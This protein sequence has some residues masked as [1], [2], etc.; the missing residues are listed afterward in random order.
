MKQPY[1]T[2]NVEYDPNNRK[3]GM[4]FD[5]VLE[6]VAK[7]YGG[8]QSGGGFAFGSGSGMRDQDFCFLDLELARRFLLAVKRFK[9]IHNISSYSN[10]C[11]ENY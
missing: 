7:R 1:V 11:N 3:E 5:Y 10:L 6:K 9:S 4:R 2:V 8:R